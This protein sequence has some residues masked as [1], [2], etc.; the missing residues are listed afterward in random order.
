MFRYD[1]IIKYNKKRDSGL[2]LVVD[3][4]YPE[5]LHSLKKD[6]LFLLEKSN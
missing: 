6:L 3:V 4:D 2:K 1:F 5:C